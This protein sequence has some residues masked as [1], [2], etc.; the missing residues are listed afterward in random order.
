VF[1]KE[2]VTM[3]NLSLVGKKANVTTTADNRQRRR[4]FIEPMIS[5]T[6]ATHAYGKNKFRVEQNKENNAFIKRSLLEN[7][8]SE[9]NKQSHYIMANDNNDEIPVNSPNATAW[10][11][12]QGL[13]FQT[14]MKN[15]AKVSGSAFIEKNNYNKS[16]SAPLGKERGAFSHECDDES[17]DGVQDEPPPFETPP[18]YWRQ[19]FGNNI[20][21]SKNI[22]NENNHMIAKSSH[23][24]D[25]ASPIS[26]LHVEPQATPSPSNVFSMD[27]TI[28]QLR[29]S[30]K[31]TDEAEVELEVERWIQQVK[32]STLSE[33]E[34]RID[35]KDSMKNFNFIEMDKFISSTHNNHTSLI[36][37]I[38]SPGDA[39]ECFK[40]YNTS[41][42]ETEEEDYTEQEQQHAGEAREILRTWLNAED[43][44][45]KIKLRAKTNA[46]LNDA[47]AS[48]QAYRSERVQNNGKAF[49]ETLRNSN[50]KEIILDSDTIQKIRSTSSDPR[51]VI[52][53]RQKI[54]NEKRKR[55]KE[56]Q[57]RLFKERQD[58]TINMGKSEYNR[59][60]AKEESDKRRQWRLRQKAQREKQ[61]QRL[62]RVSV[63]ESPPPFHRE[64]INNHVS[65]TSAKKVN[66]LSKSIV[67]LNSLVEQQENEVRQMRI[68]YQ[69]K[70]KIEREEKE[71]T[72]VKEMLRLRL[73]RAKREKILIA[74]EEMRRK[75]NASLMQT[76][77]NNWNEFTLR[78]I[79]RRFMEEESKAN[80][81]VIFLKWSVFVKTTVFERNAFI[82]RKTRVEQYRLWVKMSHTFNKWSIFCKERKRHK[83]K[84]RQI[85]RFTQLHRKKRVW[86]KWKLKVK[87][88]VRRRENGLKATSFYQWRRKNKYFT[89]WCTY[90]N[91][92]QKKRNKRIRR[93]K[94]DKLVTL[95][96][97]TQ[98][99]A[100][101]EVSRHE[102]DEKYVTEGVRVATKVSPY[103]SKYNDEEG[104]E[105]DDNSSH[106]TDKSSKKPP[107][108]HAW[109]VTANNEY[110]GKY[111]EFLS[112]MEKRAEERKIKREARRQ[113]RQLAEQEMLYKEQIKEIGKVIFLDAAK[114]GR[115][116]LKRCDVKRRKIEAKQ[117]AERIELAK[118]KYGDA[119]IKNTELCMKYYGFRPWCLFMILARMESVRATNHFH[120]VV[121]L[122]AMKDWK[123]FTTTSKRRKAVEILRKEARANMHFRNKLK[124]KIFNAMLMHHNALRIREEAV[125]KQNE[126][127]LQKDCLRYLRSKARELRGDRIIRCQRADVFYRQK[128]EL[129]VFKSWVDAI[130]LLREDKKATMRRR[131]LRSRVNSWLKD[132][133][134]L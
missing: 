70:L 49:H 129:N 15:K 122:K 43:E 39:R 2:Q 118:K 89:K 56:R 131:A 79:D 51:L 77:F 73:E 59:F 61:L 13:L 20:D 112:A 3:Y 111:C 85:N 68:Q 83:R 98:Q 69:K 128:L 114:G 60:K 108:L 127:R 84:Q 87:H 62:H 100:M 22:Y 35:Q 52:E 133:D 75:R 65:S 53:E 132:D 5:P 107:S 116:F 18:S 72:R 95:A 76:Y 55:R 14:D 42:T 71:K 8:Q 64:K 88:I 28:N 94:F 12:S 97:T 33:D 11:R 119:I 67:K 50:R 91:D 99:D 102:L 63:D 54:L 24:N 46:L 17:D 115:K 27:A 40:G 31:D 34:K 96:T 120:R 80:L 6:R 19:R 126:Y 113:R 37:L 23:D 66:P 106:I 74:K 44:A 93:K 58:S 105:M 29:V 90:V 81:K 109:R 26:M 124:V 57:E 123:H 92:V 117:K 121:S 103:E 30:K 25:E 47:V 45:A 86:K 21:N 101:D 134:R 41:D 36:Q 16:I 125:R 78:S 48:D 130:P 10:L 104:G 9:L 1:G 82:K 32:E 38:S 4:P 7:R 110:E